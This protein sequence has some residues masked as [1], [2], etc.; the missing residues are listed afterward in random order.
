ML[1]KTAFLTEIFFTK[2]LFQK[3]TVF[4]LYCFGNP[5][6]LFQDHSA[7]HFEFL[8]CTKLLIQKWL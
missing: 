8:V 2:L 4:V 7:G 6:A 3:N 1:I 5:L